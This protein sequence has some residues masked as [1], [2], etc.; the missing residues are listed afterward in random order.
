MCIRMITH[1]LLLS[2]LFIT[3]YVINVI[4]PTIQYNWLAYPYILSVVGAVY[5]HCIDA[6]RSDNMH[7]NLIGKPLNWHVL[8]NER[9]DLC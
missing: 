5:D 7:C 9:I 6:G 3:Y 2:F 8:Y 1:H 4:L